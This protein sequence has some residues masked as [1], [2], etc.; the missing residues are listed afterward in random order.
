M[1]RAKILGIDISGI[2][3][4]AELIQARIASYQVKSAS[5]ASRRSGF[6]KTARALTAPEKTTL[7]PGTT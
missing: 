4:N 5:N 7:P 6:T 1:E 3:D 2:E